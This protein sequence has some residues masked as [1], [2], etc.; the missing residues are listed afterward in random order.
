[1][2]PV[3]VQIIWRFNNEKFLVVVVLVLG[4]VG[5]VAV[6][7]APA[8]ARNNNITTADA[9]EFDPF[10][11]PGEQV[12][13]GQARLRTSE[14]GATLHLKTAELEPGIAVL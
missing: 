7:V 13:G 12:E 9:F 8:T 10:P 3:L 2:D 4:V 11:V 6:L 5:L 1:M 14:Q